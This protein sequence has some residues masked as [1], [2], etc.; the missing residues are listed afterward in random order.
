MCKSRL[1]LKCKDVKCYTIQRLENIILKT[2]I[3]HALAKKNDQ[4]NVLT[5]LLYVEYRIKDNK[6]V[7]SRSESSQ[8]V[9]I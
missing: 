4:K 7:Q 5:E 9:V 1:R 3:E 8:T 2:D 6:V